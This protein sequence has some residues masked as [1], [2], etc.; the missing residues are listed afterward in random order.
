MLI[1]LVLIVLLYFVNG[2]GIS[3]AITGGMDN[4]GRIFRSLLTAGV[5]IAFVGCIYLIMYFQQK[6][7]PGMLRHPIW[8]K[9]P[10]LTFVVGFISIVLFLSLGTFGPLMEWID[11][12]KWLLYVLAIYFIWLFFL[13]IMSIIVKFKRSQNRVLDLTFAWTCIV[14]LVSIFIF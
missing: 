5:L 14:L 12:L 11:H 3:I 9:M 10:I 13:F 7:N 6:K 1:I 2:F 4:E 8:S